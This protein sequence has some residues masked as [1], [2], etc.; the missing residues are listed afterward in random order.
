VRSIDIAVAAGFGDT[1]LGSADLVLLGFTLDSNVIA[2]ACQGDG[3][4]AATV[5]ATPPP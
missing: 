3:A 2:G 1:S 4:A 5:A